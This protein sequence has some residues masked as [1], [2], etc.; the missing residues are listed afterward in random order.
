MDNMEVVRRVS[1]VEAQLRKKSGKAKGKMDLKREHVL[2]VIHSNADACTIGKPR[3]AI[4]W[5]A[6]MELIA[7]RRHINKDMYL[8]PEH[9]ELLTVK[10]LAA[11]GQ[12]PMGAAHRVEIVQSVSAWLKE[13]EEQ[14]GGVHVIRPGKWTQL[15]G[16]RKKLAAS[17]GGADALLAAVT[18]LSAEGKATMQQRPNRPANKGKWDSWVEDSVKWMVEHDWVSSEEAGSLSAKA[19][20]T[21]Q[22][23]EVKERTILVLN[24]GEGWRSVGRGVE[25][26]F[27]GAVVVGA[28][29]RGFTWV[30]TVVGKITAELQHDWS[31]A[32]TD[33]I[34]ALSKKAGVS[35]RAWSLVTLEPECTLFSAANAMNMADGTAHGKWAMLPQNLA[36]ATS[37]RIE[38]EMADYAAARRGVVIQL[39]SLEK[40]PYIPFIVENP[41]D[42]EL[43]SL[44]EVLEILQRNKD[45]VIREVDRCAYGREE[46]KP[47]KFLTNRPEWKPKGRTGDGR[48]CA[49]KCT[50]TLTAA[51]KTEHPRQTLANSKEKRVDCGKLVGGRREWTAKAVVNAIEK[52]LIQEAYPIIMKSAGSGLPHRGQTTTTTTEDV[53]GGKNRKRQR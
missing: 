45:W 16:A 26:A 44:P 28:D 40:H 6:T 21:A 23:H 13:N 17:R 30:G 53:N 38:D 34:T 11:M 8:Q 46:K 35:V 15:K 25:E 22:Q 4:V 18:L 29:R 37:E 24:L 27:P 42:S 31:T 36:N 12:V 39:T 5:M 2:G 19:L 14:K 7:T 3:A 43:W 51:G 9:T 1:A 48:C 47:T 41:A 50:G 32:T 20:S 52:E 33:L 10:G 49:G